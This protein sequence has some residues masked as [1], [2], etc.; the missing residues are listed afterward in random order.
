MSQGY[1]R[2]DR[3]V[4]DYAL[5]RATPDGEDLRG[6]PPP[7]LAPKS[8][9]ACVGAAQTFGCFVERPWPALLAARIGLPALNLG[10]AGAGPRLF[11]EPRW[12]PLLDAAAFVVFQVMSGRSADCSRFS[13]GGRERL[14]I[15]ADGRTL[16]ADQAWGEALFA[17]VA[18]WRNPLVR[19]VLNRVH[20]RFGRR[21]LR[22]LVEETQADW[23]ASFRALLDATRAPKLVLWFGKRA[24]RHR[25]RF[26]SV[27]ALFGEFPQ[28]VDERMLDA[29]TARADGLVTCVTSRGSPQPLRDKKTGAPVVVRPVDAGSGEDPRVVWTHNAYYP[30]PEMHEDAAEALVAPCHA[31][32]SRVA[33]RVHSTSR[34]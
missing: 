2:R 6:P 34:T 15:R 12:G 8:Y 4:V 3:D 5:W 21:D 28:L 25:P 16:G 24:P 32:R 14:T 9:F 19:G 1:Q 23:V 22:R 30:S 26:H 17:D 27:P 11:L 33:A 29:I 7:S 18:R 10:V 13:S 20:A 31:L